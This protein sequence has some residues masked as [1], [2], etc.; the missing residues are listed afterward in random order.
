MKILMQAQTYG[1]H[2]PTCEDCHASS[3]VNLLQ[4]IYVTG[5]NDLTQ[6]KDLTML[7]LSVY[8]NPNV[9]K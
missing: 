9:E 1:I 3:L 7:I 2:Q 6:Y 8:R 5:V 4:P